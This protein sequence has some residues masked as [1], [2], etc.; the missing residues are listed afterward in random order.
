MILVVNLKHGISHPVS[1]IIF[2]TSRLLGGPNFLKRGNL[3]NKVVHRYRS[4]RRNQKNSFNLGKRDE[5]RGGGFCRVPNSTQ[6]SSVTAKR[7][8]TTSDHCGMGLERRSEQVAAKDGGTSCVLDRQELSSSFVI[9]GRSYVSC[10]LC[11]PAKKHIAFYC[12]SYI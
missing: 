5:R 6:K 1:I 12:V 11:I 4:T 9:K 3:R 2:P 7:T 10:Y 8:A